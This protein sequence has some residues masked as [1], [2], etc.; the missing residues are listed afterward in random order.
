MAETIASTDITHM[1]HK[2]AS[3]YHLDNYKIKSVSYDTSL[4]NVGLGNGISVTDAISSQKIPNTFHLLELDSTQFYT[5]IM[6]NWSKNNFNPAITAFV[7]DT[8]D[9]QN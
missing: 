8:L 1:V 5:T 6:M 4:L 2:F 9:I 3:Y 7:K